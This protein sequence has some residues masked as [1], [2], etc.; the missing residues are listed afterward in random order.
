MIAS[1]RGQVISRSLNR[2]I[3][4][5]HGVG[6][7]VAVSITTAESLSQTGEVFLHIHTALRENALE[8]YGFKTEEEKALF[9]MLLSVAGIGPRTSMLILSGI[10]PDGFKQAVLE[11]D[12]HKLTAIPGI[13]RKSAERI[14][15]ELKDKIRRLSPEFGLL[16]KG[17]AATLEDDLASSLVNLGYPERTAMAAARK[18]I[19]E[20]EPGLTLS[21][22][23]KLALKHLMK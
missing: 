9:E 2:V 14:V 16:G 23:V 6:Y 5:T 17:R 1:L 3:I 18:V 8:L 22:M 21:Q 10:S 15:L 11:G 13:G 4:D 12:L 20:S 19:K 7:D